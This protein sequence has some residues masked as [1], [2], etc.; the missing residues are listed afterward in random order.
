[1]VFVVS[2]TESVNLYSQEMKDKTDAKYVSIGSPVDLSCFDRKVIQKEL[3]FKK[4]LPTKTYIYTGRLSAFKNVKT[5]IDAVYMYKNKVNENVT[6]VVAGSGDEWDAIN[7][8]IIELNLQ[9]N[10]KMLGSVSHNEIY[11]LLEKADVFLT[12]SGGEGVSVSVIEA[13][14]AGLPVVCFNVPGLEKQ[15]LNNVTGVIA[16]EKNAESFFKAMLEVDRKRFELSLNCLV[17]AQKY[18]AGKISKKII[19]E[20]NSLF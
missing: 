12:A 4:N 9:N 3:D 15:V 8:Q 16:E 11:S 18:E 7:K 20:I 10:V 2:D 17:E 19:S 13:Y 6:L 5:L 14:A 1:M